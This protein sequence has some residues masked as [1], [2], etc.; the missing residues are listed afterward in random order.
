M[1]G[2][3]IRIDEIEFSIDSGSPFE[4]EGIHSGRV[5]SGINLDIT[6]YSDEDVRRIEA[7]KKSETVE[8]DDPFSDKLYEA[9]L[10]QESYGFREGH[11]KRWYRFEVKEL[12]EVP[13]FNSL[14][15]DGCRF[16]VLRNTEDLV[17]DGVKREDILLRLSLEE[18]KEVQDLLNRD[19]VTIRRVGIDD[20]PVIR[21][22]G[23]ALYWS[24]HQEGSQEFYKQ[25]VRLFPS[26][27]PPSKVVLA[28]GQQQIAQSR[29]ILNLLASYESLLELLAENGQIRRED[30][31]SLL[32][33]GLR[34]LVGQ[35]R[36]MMIFSKLTEVQDAEIELD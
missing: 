20:D 23:G 36:A 10:S 29:M 17:R 22:F 18:F 27:Y 9:N 3:G 1:Q 4:F 28:S 8:V 30:A 34:E 14:E 11:P 13:K 32:S 24:L 6:V 12:D 19:T 35:E 31:E 25:I 26:D 33:K 21:R 5:L 16:R 15:I 2:R 7:L